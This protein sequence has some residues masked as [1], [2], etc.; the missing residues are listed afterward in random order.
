MELTHDWR[1]FRSVFFGKRNPS[2]PLLEGAIYLIL[3]NK[4]IICALSE[5]DDLSDWVGATEDELRVAFPEKEL[6]A[7]D[8]Q[9]VDH[10]LTEAREFSHFY[11]QTRFLRLK[12]KPNLLKLKRI[13]GGDTLVYGHFF[14]QAI[15]TWWRRLFPS[16]YGVYIQLDGTDSTSVFMVVQRGKVHQFHVPDLSSLPIERKRHS[17]QIIKYLS[18]RYLMPVQGLFVTS[19]EWLDWSETQDPWPKVVAAI[20]S[21]RNK[22]VPFKVSLVTLIASRAYLKI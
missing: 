4:V 21:N 12:A 2:S 13:N 19:A 18:E 5:S 9:K 1:S 10:W 16:T 8:K 17:S 6:I 22:L 20:R 14:L 7:F 11:D 3:N 15:Q